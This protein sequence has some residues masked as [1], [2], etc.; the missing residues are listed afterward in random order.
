VSVVRPLECGW[1]SCDLGVLIAGQQGTT[2]I[3]VP[4][5]LVE[6]AE[7]LVLFDTG[8]HPELIDDNERLRSVASMFQPALGEDE[9]VSARL[10]QIG[11]DPR[12]VA[13]IACS[14]LHF[15]HCGGHS[16]VPDARLLVQRPEWD[17]AH[18]PGMID[19]GAY[20]PDD[21]EVGHDVELVEGEHDIFGD[22]ALVLVPTDGHTVGHQSLVVDGRTILVGDACYCQLALDQDALP[23]FSADE[24][25]QRA[26]FRWLRERQAAGQTVIYSHDP[27]QWAT[28]PARL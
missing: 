26:S 9:L 10:G 17:A 22:G 20:N 19:L 23:P 12:Q 11:V 2:R 7:G 14:H 27:A 8:M 15:D 28:L 4:A 21:F 6:H 5:F 1:L 16:L 3:P 18:D 25:R 24:A 13:I